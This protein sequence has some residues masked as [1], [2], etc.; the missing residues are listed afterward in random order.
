MASKIL[1]AFIE[2]PKADDDQSTLDDGDFETGLTMVTST[3]ISK[4]VLMKQGKLPWDDFIKK[5]EKDIDL[6]SYVN[7]I[8]KY[9]NLMKAA[10]IAPNVITELADFGS[11]MRNLRNKYKLYSEMIKKQ[12]DLM[13]T[14]ANEVTIGQKMLL[15]N[16]PII[17]NNLSVIR[18]QMENLKA[19][20]SDKIN[21]HI[22][23]LQNE[24]IADDR[25]LLEN[26]DLINIAVANDI[27][28]KT[29]RQLAFSEVEVI[30][31]K[32]KVIPEAVLEK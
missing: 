6:S 29:L 1:K 7:D 15:S 3:P 17:K 26:S 28:D 22:R 8:K 11:E 20:M 14:K 5:Y 4:M 21:D 9:S 25:F 16:L 19:G 13:T 12:R 27:D 23:Y 2:E 32:K 10:G 30:K 18:G 24:R 31:G